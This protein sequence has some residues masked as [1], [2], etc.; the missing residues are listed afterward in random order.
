M[1][2]ENGKEGEP[3]GQVDS[4]LPL[5]LGRMAQVLALALL[6]PLAAALLWGEDAL[7]FFLPAL[8]AAAGGTLLA[9][10]AAMG[11]GGRRQMR[12]VESALAM[13]GVWPFLALFSMQP[14]LL[15]HVLSSPAAAFFE[16]MSALTTTGLSCLSYP[17]V[18]VRSVVLWH[19]LLCWVGGGVFVI[20]LVA[21]L[22]NVSGCFGLTLT[23]R[24]SLSFSPVWNRMVASVRQGLSVYAALTA[25]SSVL[26]FLAGLM[27]LAAVTRAMVT[28]SS[29]GSADYA[30]FA[31]HANGALELAGGVTMLFAGMNL[32]LCWRAWHS[33]R[34][35][36]L[37]HDMELRLY[38]FGILASGFL[39]SAVLFFHDRLALFDSLRYG[40]FHA[41]SFLT[42]TG[43][44]AAPLA[45]WSPFARLY[46]LLLAF[47]G[48]CIGA[49]GGGLKL[50]RVAVLVRLALAEVRRTLHPHMVVSIK[51]DG[52]AV[53]PKIAQRIL[54]F[55]YLFV[56][57][58]FASSLVLSL[59]GL[60]LMR[61]MAVAAGCL[62]STGAAASLF[63]PV[64]FSWAPGW[65]QIFASVV[66]VL[67]RVEIF[68]FLILLD[69]GVRYF[70]HHW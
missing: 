38:V 51:M 43:Y 68:S 46:L 35:A 29:G 47:V 53:A 65:M 13:V 6:V 59:S 22:P 8:C 69:Q 60:P 24:Q 66:M 14:F 41:V 63:A 70:R 9:R 64:G 40:F 45:D 12:V 3:V 19:S 26:Y 30:L 10:L 4:L 18:T 36:L 54:T 32:L 31:A 5:F 61:A 7:P 17:E 42:T 39:L 15:A 67:G 1:I 34:F 25:V 20:V 56:A 11:E 50:M 48:G 37:W 55:F 33:R 2:A 44:V 16:S 57:V 49:A 62:T 28:V 58:F 27:P 21:I 52:L 23:A